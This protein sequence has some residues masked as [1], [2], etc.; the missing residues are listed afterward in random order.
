MQTALATGAEND[1]ENSSHKQLRYR[2]GNGAKTLP[3]WRLLFSRLF[4]MGT[5]KK[6]KL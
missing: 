6:Y 2:V 1:I 3:V 5:A 4:E